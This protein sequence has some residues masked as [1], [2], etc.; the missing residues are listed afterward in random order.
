M[1]NMQPIPDAAIDQY[2]I[3]VFFLC[4]VFC[5]TDLIG[6]SSDASTDEDIE[7]YE[8]W[9]VGAVSDRGPIED[10]VGL[11]CGVCVPVDECMGERDLSGA[12]PVDDKVRVVDDLFNDNF[13]L[14][15]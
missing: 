15:G 12:I 11:T 10:C 13:E 9:C 3:G 4:L 7:G 2:G 8:L 1:T 14:A 5:R 6:E